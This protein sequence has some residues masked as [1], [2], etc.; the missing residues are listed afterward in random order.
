[1]AN[2]NFRTTHLGIGGPGDA[3][4][5]S[6]VETGNLGVVYQP[7]VDIRKRR[8]F[9]YEAL[10]RP[11]DRYFRDPVHLFEEASAHKLAGRLGRMIREIA[12]GQCPD[13]PLFLNIHPSELDAHY[14]VQPNDPIFQHDHDVYLEI[15][16]GVPITHFALCKQILN[17]VSGRGI[18]LVVD[19]LGAGYSNLKYIADLSP[20]IVKI[21][22][23]LVSGLVLESRMH[24]LVRAIVNL[25]NELDAR[26][27]AEGIETIAEYEAVREAGVHYAQGYLLAKPAFPPPEPEIP[28]LSAR[29]SRRSDS[30]KPVRGPESVRAGRVSS[31]PKKSSR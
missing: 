26:V 15:T 11:R 9:A 23:G 4:I 19:D 25:C 17:D 6:T 30:L 7:I 12:I 3:H 10:V 27:V 16:E 20:R 22:R 29:G 8:T 5:K 2:P 31:A 24:R 28:G 14:L 18:Y 1:M 13:Y 21:D